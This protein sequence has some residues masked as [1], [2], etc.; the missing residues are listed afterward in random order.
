MYVTNSTH[1]FRNNVSKINVMN[2]QDSAWDLSHSIY[3]A[4]DNGSVN[5]GLSIDD[6]RNL[7]KDLNE[8]IRKFDALQ[9]ADLPA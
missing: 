8:A 2:I 6:V 9:A 7:A 1:S 3:I 4:Y 5:I